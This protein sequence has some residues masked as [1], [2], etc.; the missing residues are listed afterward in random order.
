MKKTPYLPLA[1]VCVGLFLMLLSVLWPAAIPI[2]TVYS[3]EDAEAWSAS[4]LKAKGAKLSG[5]LEEAK[6][7]D[8]ELDARNAEFESA[9]AFYTGPATFFKW[10]GIV[11]TL[12]GAGGFYVL[13]AMA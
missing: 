13:R 4:I 8:Q 3:E 10:S 12:L 6:Q 1:V 11:I 5:N 9:Q 2:N 7:A